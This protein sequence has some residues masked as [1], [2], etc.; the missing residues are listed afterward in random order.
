MTSGVVI[1]VSGSLPKNSDEV[2]VF[3][4]TATEL[5]MLCDRLAPLRPTILNPSSRGDDLRDPEAAFGRDVLQIRLS[6]AI[7]V[8]ARS[9]R[10]IGVGAEMLLAKTLSIPLVSLCPPGSHY[11]R[12]DL[13][14]LGQNLDEWTH[15]FVAALSDF[16]APDVEQATDWLIAN[17]PKPQLPPKGPE[18]IDETI[19]HYMQTQL[20]R[21]PEMGAF[22]RAC[23]E[24]APLV[25]R[26]ERRRRAA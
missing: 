3:S 15:P 19:A 12:S 25:A 14:F 10:G 9:K 8:D 18:V 1:Y 21:D 22:L 20:H 23:P 2:G 24:R 26:R 17:L 7:V 11:R 16:I 5:A 13:T 4:W 6:D